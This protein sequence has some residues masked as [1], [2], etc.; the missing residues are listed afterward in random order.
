[1]SAGT[2]TRDRST[3]E[4]ARGLA[5][6]L[7]RLAQRASPAGLLEELE[8]ILEALDEAREAGIVEDDTY[9]ELEE[10]AA[11]LKG[12]SPPGAVPRP[13]A[14]WFEGLCEKLEEAVNSAYD[15]ETAERIKWRWTALTLSARIAGSDS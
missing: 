13:G 6:E 5:Y 1:M 15:P 14:D 7:R 11:I 2:N 10:F 3:E 4:A 12:E 9:R 8:A